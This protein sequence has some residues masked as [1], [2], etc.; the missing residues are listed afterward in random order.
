MSNVYTSQQLEAQGIVGFGSFTRK[1][2]L[3]AVH[4]MW[5]EGN[6]LGKLNDC[7]EQ[8]QFMTRIKDIKI[9][10]IWN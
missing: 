2:Y 9:K 10:S 3:D 5:Q 6:L 4:A 1:N 7:I 8:V